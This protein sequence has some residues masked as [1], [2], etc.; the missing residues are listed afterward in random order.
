MAVERTNNEEKDKRRLLLLI[1]III[2]LIISVILASVVIF[3]SSRDNA[4]IAGTKEVLHDVSDG[5]VRVRINSFI[6]VNGETMD[7]LEFCN[8]NE[9]RLMRCKIR[10]ADSSK[11][12]YKS[13]L[14]ES[15]S[16]IQ[17]D[18]LR[19][20]KL[21]DGNNNCIAEIYTY[22]PKTEEQIGQINV[23]IILHK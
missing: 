22:D 21:Q 8:I 2:L 1:L 23:E 6:N 4:V 20:N 9:N 3:S 5:Q 19:R 11:Y 18:T 13:K 7:N 16:V 17:S 10:L 14:I 15:G 12:I